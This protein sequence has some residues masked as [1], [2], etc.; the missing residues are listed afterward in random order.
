MG[1]A[2]KEPPK[3]RLNIQQLDDKKASKTD[4]VADTSSEKRDDQNTTNMKAD[5]YPILQASSAFESLC[6]IYRPFAATALAPIN[7]AIDL[8]DHSKPEA[9]LAR[10]IIALSSMR[11]STAHSGWVSSIASG[12]VKYKI[13]ADAMENK[14][15]KL[16]AA[17]GRSFRIE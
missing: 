3:Q 13:G 2:P 12:K 14:V 16:M 8:N 10:L 9:I 4:K 11:Y 1:R 7:A 6:A 15:G 17:K 5:P